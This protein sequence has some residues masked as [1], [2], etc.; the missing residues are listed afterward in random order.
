MACHTAFF[1]GIQVPA[2]PAAVA[3]PGRNSL[4][5]S[6]LSSRSYTQRWYNPLRRR[7]YNHSPDF[8]RHWIEA[9][10]PTVASHERFLIVS[11][12]ILGDRN[13]SK[14]KDLYRN[15]PPLYM[16]W[17]H[18]KSV[19]C[20]EILGW[21]PDL[22]CLQE[23]DRFYD[24]LSIMQKAG[25]IGLYKRRTGDNVDGCAVFWKADKL[26]L[27]GGESIEFK[28]HGL[29]DN[30]A[31][32]SVFEMIKTK[33]RFVVGNIHVLYNPSRG[34]VKLGQV[35]MLS[36][37]AHILSKTW[38]NLPVVLAGDFNS[39]PESAIY[40]FLSSSELNIVAYDRRE[41]SGQKNCHPAQRSS[42]GREIWDPLVLIDGLMRGSWND[43][44]VKIA[45]GHAECLIAVHPLNLRSSYATVN[46][47]DFYL[48]NTANVFILVP[49]LQA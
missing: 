45:T 39:T 30:V 42:T 19:V 17:S 31:Q 33:R 7:R 3:R 21:S 36:S 2:P 49:S 40:R 15:V 20:E 22:I 26:H 48:Q 46:V 38:G 44:A 5:T 35:R 1:V 37:R 12:N 16:K 9:Q 34:D 18:R 10:P 6:P 25:Y 8:V 23:V 4:P 27:L 47:L 14:H 13:A 29:R 24:L 43:E 28:R 32:L 41:L 11:Y